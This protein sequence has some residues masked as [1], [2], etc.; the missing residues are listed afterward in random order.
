[1]SSRNLA[2]VLNNE[3]NLRILEKLKERPF[4]PRE[5]AGEMG[6]SEPFIVRRL[7]AM[8]VHDIVEGRWETEGMRRVKRYYLKD[9]NIRLGRKGLEVTTGKAP[10]KRRI[11]VKNELL[12][13]LFRLPL[14]AL[15]VYGIFFNVSLV[16]GAVCVYFLWNAA[17]DYAFY[18]DFRLKTPLFSMA[19]NV[20]IAALLVTFLGDSYLSLVPMEAM[21][22]ASFVGLVTLLLILIYRSRF[23][24]MEV[25]ELF[26]DMTELMGRI[27]DTSLY[28]KAF[29]L[30]VVAR[31]KANEYFGLI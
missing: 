9:V 11:E 2:G 30:P 16:V 28:V 6:L 14:I 1:V 25:D 22:V 21:A 10:A 13:T 20:S 15:L 24:Q 4:Y 12:G 18:R 8:E 31:W 3:S 5:M 7:K 23:Y 19:V 26:E 27:G 17:I 29:Y